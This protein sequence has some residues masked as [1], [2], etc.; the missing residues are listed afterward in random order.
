M[1]A[2]RF[3]LRNP[4]LLKALLNLKGRD[5]SNT[6]KAFVNTPNSSTENA[7]KS[8]KNRLRVAKRLNYEK[9]LEK[10]KS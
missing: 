5:L 3:N 10:L 7:F 6:F 9:Q 2:K 4:G 8:F 1:K